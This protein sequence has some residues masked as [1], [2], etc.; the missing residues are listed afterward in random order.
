MLLSGT[1]IVENSWLL[2]CDKARLLRASSL[3]AS[4]ARRGADEFAHVFVGARVRQVSS[5]ARELPRLSEDGSPAAS[6]LRVTIISRCETEMSE[7]SQ[8]AARFFNQKSET[9]MVTKRIR[10]TTKKKSVQKYEVLKNRC[11]ETIIN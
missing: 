9:R 1:R 3:T 11:K 5:Y 4:E 7:V 10:R 2:S 6:K 8:E